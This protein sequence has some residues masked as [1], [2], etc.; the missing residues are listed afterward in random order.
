MGFRSRDGQ[1]LVGHLPVAATALEDAGGSGLE[2]GIV[3]CDAVESPGDGEVAGRAD[4]KARNVKAGP[5]R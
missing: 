1:V 5:P 4:G 3:S 2:L